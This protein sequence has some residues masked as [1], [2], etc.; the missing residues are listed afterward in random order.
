MTKEQL[1]Q[2]EYGTKFFAEGG[3][4]VM[5][6]GYSIDAPKFKKYETSMLAAAPTAAGGM[7]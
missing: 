3:S 5:D 2:Q 4:N 1:M 7:A 6:S